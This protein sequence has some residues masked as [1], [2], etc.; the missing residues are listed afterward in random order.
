MSRA[1]RSTRATSNAGSTRERCSAVEAVSEAGG[2]PRKEWTCVYSTTRTEHAG[3]FRGGCRIRAFYHEIAMLLDCHALES[4]KRILTSRRNARISVSGAVSG[5]GGGAQRMEGT[6]SRPR[7]W[8]YACIRRGHGFSSPSL[9]LP[10]AR[11][12]AC[13]LAHCAC[14]AR[15]R[16]SSRVRR[17]SRR[18]KRSFVFANSRCR[19]ATRARARSAARAALKASR[20]SRSIMR[21]VT[22]RIRAGMTGCGVTQEFSRHWH[23]RVTSCI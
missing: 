16:A 1:Q 21:G 8:S 4:A 19:L 9:P 11:S 3:R 10:L 23:R 6:P 2:R 22:T 7:E 14:S 13:T 5:W 17:A 12:S 15:R 20:E 18:C